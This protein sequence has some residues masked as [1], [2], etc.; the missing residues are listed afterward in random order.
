M[1]LAKSG[2]IRKVLFKG[3]GA[4]IFSKFRPPPPPIQRDPFKDS[5]PPH[6]KLLVIRILIANSAHTHSYVCG[7]FIYYIQL[8]AM[9]L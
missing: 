6:S 1:D 9:A 3:R 4:E 7:L 2:L 8:L 5:E